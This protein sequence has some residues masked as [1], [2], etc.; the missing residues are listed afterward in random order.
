MITMEK[1][2]EWAVEAE[3]KAVSEL[4]AFVDFIE[5]KSAVDDAVALLESNGYT[6]TPPQPAPV[7]P[8]PVVPA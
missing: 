2:R 8:P 4:H 6:V 5:G 1:L 7:T 3:Q